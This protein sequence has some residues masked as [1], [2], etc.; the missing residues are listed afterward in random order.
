MVNSLCRNSLADHSKIGP[1]SG[2]GDLQQLAYR[3][4]DVQN[5]TAFTFL[6]H[7]VARFISGFDKAVNQVNNIKDPSVQAILSPRA[8]NRF[9]NFVK[10]Y[11]QEGPKILEKGGVALAQLMS[12]T[13]FLNLWPGRIKFVGRVEAFFDSIIQLEKVMGKNLTVPQHFTLGESDIDSDLLNDN[14]HETIQLLHDYFRNEIIRFGYS[15][16][17]GYH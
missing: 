15:P 3:E 11:V 7:P 9:D 2:C 1:G 8:P 5:I 12:Q 16:F 14:H 13:F 17:G 6:R 4:T 10:K